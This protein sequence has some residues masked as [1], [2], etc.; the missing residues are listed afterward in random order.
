M[1]NIQTLATGVANA[2]QRISTR[3]FGVYDSTN[4]KR[5]TVY[6]YSLSIQ[7]RLPGNLALDVGYVG[8]MQR[9][10]SITFDINA[11]LPGTAYRPEF[12]EPGNVGYNFRGAISSSNPGPALPGSNT[13][14]DELMRP[15]RGLSTLKLPANV[16]NARHHALQTSFAKRFGHGLSLQGSYTLSKTYSQVQNFGL[17]SYNWKDY[18]GFLQ[19]ASRTHVFKLNYIYDLP[20]F[21]KW[22]GWNHTV[23]REALDGWSLAQFYAYLSGAPYTP[24]F[25]IVNTGSSTFLNLNRVFTGT[26]SLAPRLVP[27]GDVQ[28]GSN[29]MLFNPSALAIPAIFPAANG[30]GSLNYLTMPSTFGNDLSLS[31]RIRVRESKAIEL[32]ISAYNA[33]NNTRRSRLNSS[34]TYRANGAN[35][36]DGFTVYNTAQQIVD[37]LPAASKTSQRQIYDFYRTGVGLIDLTTVDSNRIVEIGMRFR[38]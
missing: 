37:R 4:T 7:Q 21:S 30:T 19:S 10:Q 27:V 3:G 32:R 6:D 5:P 29:G 24:S 25:S 34:I 2:V 13:V 36:S 23:A 8:N 17:Y 22:L 11:P 26:S 15:Y 31:K 28:A 33:F 16:A 14:S 1:T 12:I 9:H 18:T 20:K 38:F 35:W